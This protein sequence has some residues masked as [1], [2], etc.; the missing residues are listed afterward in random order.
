[1]DTMA[2]KANSCISEAIV[3]ASS[4]GRGK[5]IFAARNIG[6]GDC[7][8]R[9][10]PIMRGSSQ[11]R[12]LL[13]KLTAQLQALPPD[14][15]RGFL[16]LQW[17]LRPQFPLLNR[18]F[19]NAF[20]IGN[21]PDMTPE[22]AVFLYA[23]QF[24]HSCI[25]SAYWVWDCHMERLTVYAIAHIPKGDEIF[26]NYTPLDSTPEERTETLQ[27]VYGFTCSCPICSSEALSQKREE[28]RVAAD[29][30]HTR[31]EA[32]GFED[33][34]RDKN[35]I[36]APPG[37]ENDPLPTILRL[38]EVYEHAGFPTLALAKLYGQASSCYFWRGQSHEERRYKAKQ[39]AVT[40]CCIGRE[41][42]ERTIKVVE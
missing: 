35:W 3:I 30:L 37:S 27:N 14:Q 38:I 11:D 34:R 7:L 10:E 25:P 8:V 23:A 20:D 39:H 42:A 2:A 1:M 18:F 36:K 40:T 22:G 4:P 5:G 24:N 29:R 21:E 32:L 13:A 9:E 28:R 41:A 31:L 17:P 19:A 12:D 26:I 16:E 15:Q 33:G 6:K